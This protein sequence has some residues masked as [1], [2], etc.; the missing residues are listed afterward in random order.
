MDFAIDPS[1]PPRDLPTGVEVALLMT[2]NP[3]FS[4]TLV[5]IETLAEQVTQ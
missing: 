3:D 2:R 1:I 5:G 4:L